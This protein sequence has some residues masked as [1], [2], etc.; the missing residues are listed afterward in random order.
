MQ[1]FDN[2]MN[3]VYS[4]QKTYSF[5]YNILIEF[6]FKL[7]L[8]RIEVMVMILDSAGIYEKRIYFNSI[9][10]NIYYENIKTVESLLIASKFGVSMCAAQKT[11]EIK[12]KILC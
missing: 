2:F 5:L 9:R 11:L 3:K 4:L 1:Y 10:I 8:V 6:S 7:N 12:A